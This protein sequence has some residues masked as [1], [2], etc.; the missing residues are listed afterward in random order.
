MPKKGPPGLALDGAEG[1]GTH[2]LHL[3]TRACSQGACARTPASVLRSYAALPDG[4]SAGGFGNESANFGLTESGTFCKD[5]WR[6][7][8]TG[9]QQ[10]PAGGLSST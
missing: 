6:V 10:T 9:I 3:P 2:A 8:S 4:A 1:F 5:D 7:K